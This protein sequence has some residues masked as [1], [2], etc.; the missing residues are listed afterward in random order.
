MWFAIP[1]KPENRPFSVPR[2]QLAAI[3]TYHLSNQKRQ[4]LQNVNSA[5]SGAFRPD[6]LYLIENYNSSDLEGERP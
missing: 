1:R 5:S 2:L 6:F 4:P 3:Y